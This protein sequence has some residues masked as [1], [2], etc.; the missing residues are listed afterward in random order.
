MKGT[1]FFVRLFCALVVWAAVGCTPDATQT[2]FS[3]REQVEAAEALVDR[4]TSGRG[5]DFV[6]KIT[7]QQLDGLDYFALYSEGNKVVLE[8]VD[9][10]CVASALN[11][12]LQEWCGCHI[13]WCGSSVTL[14]DVLPLPQERITK[15][16]PYKY[17][18]C[19][20]YCTFNYKEE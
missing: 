14:P 20:N 10:V 6:V 1:R 17:R 7:A 3:L 5:E 8:G 13:S 19:F 15:T 11:H 12:Y 9:G 18:Y 2:D 16:S 4:V